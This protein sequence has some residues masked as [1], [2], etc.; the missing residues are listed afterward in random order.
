M[1]FNRKRKSKLVF[2]GFTLVELLIVMAILAVLASIGIVSFRSSQVRGRDAQR[3]SDLKQ[4]AS[5]LEL[6]YSDYSKYPDAAGGKIQACP[7]N[8]ITKSGA[9]CLWGSG[10]FWDGQTLYFKVLPKDP[11]VSGDYFYRTLDSGQK[12]QLFATLENTQDKECLDGDCANSPVSYSCGTGM[13]CNFAVTSPNT[14][15]TE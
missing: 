15:A 14:S 1:Q 2:T 6:F 10:E 5:S 11:S 3:K 4:I 7:Y 13:V 12:F 9:D 8:S